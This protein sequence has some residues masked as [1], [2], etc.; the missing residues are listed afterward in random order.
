MV[1]AADIRERL[2]DFARENPYLV[3]TIRQMPREAI[4]ERLLL[5]RMLQEQIKAVYTEKILNWLDGA[6]TLGASANLEV[7]TAPIGLK[8]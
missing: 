2:S 5:D 8:A 3:E 6:G 7:Q 4:E 1:L